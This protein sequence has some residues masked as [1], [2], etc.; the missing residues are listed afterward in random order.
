MS[1]R[2]IPYAPLGVPKPL[3]DEIWIVDGPA[4]DMRFGPTSIPFTTRMTVI[5]LGARLWVH[6]P[7]TLTAKLQTKMNEL[8]MVQWLIAPNRLHWVHLKAWQDAYPSVRTYAAPGVEMAQAEG[9]FAIDA[10]LTDAPPISWVGDI[11]QVVVPG[12]YM[13]EVVF[14][15]R[16]S[17]TVIVT[18]L[19]E[20]VDPKRVKSWVL[21]VAMW[22][23]GVRA[24]NGGTPRDLAMTFW[25]KREAVR[26]AAAQIVDWPAERIVLAHGEIIEDAAQARLRKAFRWAG[27]R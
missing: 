6:S 20:N 7:V 4:I 23:D 25:P 13:T 22:A 24:P 19:I 2:L 9:G 15:H 5:R 3:G 12:A 10:V 21:R 18:D 14:F 1:D 26:R 16:A 17:R 11:D 8:G 27:G